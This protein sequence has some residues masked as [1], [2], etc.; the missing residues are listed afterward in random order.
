MKHKILKFENAKFEEI[1]VCGEV[2]GYSELKNAIGGYI[3][4]CLYN[5]ILKKNKIDIWCDEEGKLKSL[6]I[7]CIILDAER[8]NVVDV[9]VGPLVFTSFDDKGNSLELTNEQIEII[10]NSISVYKDEKT[11]IEVCVMKFE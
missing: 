10:K 8:M 3:E 11:G 4:T 5:S 6:P 7:E 2:V 1:E 9:V